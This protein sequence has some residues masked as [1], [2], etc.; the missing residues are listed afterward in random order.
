MA[1]QD[2]QPG[3]AAAGVQITP[4]TSVLIDDLTYRLSLD[5]SHHVTPR[6]ST[7]AIGAKR[8]NIHVTPP[9]S[10]AKVRKTSALARAGSS[11]SL[12]P[13]ASNW[14]NILDPF[15]IA[16]CPRVQALLE[17]K[18]L[19]WG[20]IFEL[21]RGVT[22]GSWCW[23]K[24]T[25]DRLDQLC[26]TNAAAASRV[27]KVMTGRASHMTAAA[28]ELWAEYDR[29]QAAIIENKGRGLG[30][31][32]SWQGKDNWYGGRI[33]QIGRIRKGKVKGTF[34]I[35]LEKPEIRRSHRFSRFL[36]SRR[37]LQVRVS[38]ELM[39]EQS[40]EARAFLWSHKFILC[41]RVFM[42]FHAKEN[43]VY[44]EETN[45]NYDRQC[46]RSEG[47]HH[48]L[49][50]AKFI[51]WHNPFRLNSAQ[52]ISKWATRWA[53]GLST[54]VP[55][56][57]FE[58]AHIYLIDDEYV[59]PADWGG[60][61]APAEKTYTDG[62]GWMNGAALT[63]IMGIMQYPTRPTAVQGRIGGAKG[64]WVLHPDPR[65]QG[66]EGILKIWIRGSQKKISLSEPPPPSQRKFEL[67]APSRVSGPSRLSSQTLV[68][69]AHNG[70]P[71]E[72]IK[73][74]MTQGL[75]GD[76]QEL[77]AWDEPHSMILVWRAVEKAGHVG[78]GRMRRSNAGELRALG[79]G[80]LRPL[81]S[82][83][84]EDEDFEALEEASSEDFTGRNPYS[85]Q[86]VT[87]H[88]VTM[89]LLQAGFHPLK[90]K[91]LFN[92]LEFILTWVIDNYVKDFHI[93]VAES[94]EAYIVPDPY[95]VLNENEIHFK[96]SDPIIDPI[97]GAQTNSIVGAVLVWRNPTRLPS[98]VQKVVAVN[99]PM[100][101][102]YYNV[103]VFPVKGKYTL[104]SYLGGGDTVVVTWNKDL[105]D[106]FR[107]ADRIEE[108]PNL[109]EAFEREVEHVK[110]FD[111]RI[112]ALPSKE[113]QQALQKTLLLGLA[114]TRV[115]L[116]SKFHDLAVYKK[117]YGDPEAV[118]LAYMFTTC[119]DA[120]KTGLRVKKTVFENDQKAWGKS[121]P[122]YIFTLE[123]NKGNSKPQESDC[124]KRA[125]KGQPFILDILVEH[126]R[127]LKDKF[128]EE[129]QSLW[130]SMDEVI[131]EDLTH[132]WKDAIVKAN[133]ARLAG[134]I[135]GLTSNLEDIEKHVEVAYDLY[136]RTVASARFKKESASGSSATGDPYTAVAREFAQEPTFREFQIFSN[137]DVRSLKASLAA[138]KSLAFA[139]S[140]AH[141]DLCAIK[142]RAAGS[143]AFT[144][145]F[146]QMMSISR[147]VA[148][149]LSRVT[150]AVDS[151]DS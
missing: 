21:A 148:R 39:Y 83:Q 14:E 75:R 50:F 131:D 41:G 28:V 107:N 9:Q 118:R 70:V 51:K 120:S 76:V 56:V 54:S 64:M 123:T 37:V 117:G 119:L 1:D 65:E 136:R 143:V 80:Q 18:R 94:M 25:E 71:Y 128:L 30:G 48:R 116:Y 150:V 23:D 90:L 109:K 20:T 103:I 27:M 142:A 66:A 44:M 68:N 53:L 63:Q 146:A 86:P 149:Y 49:S 10:P 135:T 102:N 59:T 151:T 13:R 40:D 77:T 32:G 33:Q 85:G 127:H 35:Q 140:V 129:Y 108:P 100:L 84:D 126:G 58:A 113:A 42:P 106:N 105:V 57:E 87:L 34:V 88:E 96:T 81:D 137:E 3:F 133:Q 134:N 78:L 43:N 72:V 115:G 7:S 11:G 121:K 69:V 132:L 47:D 98:D 38:E 46:V 12:A 141:K 62:C 101:A 92:K 110:D 60:G 2:S 22:N 15:I 99:H 138:T 67:L 93:P 16:H 52:P 74:L 45:E 8:T 89:E 111:H 24:V 112:S 31:M 104:A 6:L 125:T 29:E 130:T 97:T 114:E 17:R 19:A 4:P 82:Q 122:W 5:S 26:G 95:G 55:T 61:K 145:K 79:L 147:S 91:L 36:G 124:I 73:D 144:N 139:F